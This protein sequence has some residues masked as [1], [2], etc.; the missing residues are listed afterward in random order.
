MVYLFAST[1]KIP[2]GDEDRLSNGLD[3]EQQEP[4]IAD[5]RD[6][7]GNITYLPIDT[8]YVPTSSQNRA[9]SPPS[10]SSPSTRPRRQASEKPMSTPSHAR[11]PGGYF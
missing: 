7:N 8:L 4:F 9:L 3:S 2:S 6:I 11:G 10:F 5:V 1:S